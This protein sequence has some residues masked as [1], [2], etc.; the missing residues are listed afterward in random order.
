MTGVQV[1][2][3]NHLLFQ[4]RVNRQVSEKGNNPYCYIHIIRKCIDMY[5]YIYSHSKQL[6]T[7]IMVSWWIRLVVYNST[8]ILGWL[9]LVWWY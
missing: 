8:G 7:W 1:G 3:L 2:L 9:A 6:H 5:I 4:E